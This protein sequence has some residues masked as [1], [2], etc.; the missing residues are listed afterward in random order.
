MVRITGQFDYPAARTCRGVRQDSD[1]PSPAEIILGC[2]KTFV[3]TKVEP[4]S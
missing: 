4:L 1:P 2:R 3:I